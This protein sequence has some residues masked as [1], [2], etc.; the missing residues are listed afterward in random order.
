M[1]RFGRVLGSRRSGRETEAVRIPADLAAELTRHGEPLESIV[2]R[3]LRMHAGEQRDRRGG[4]PGGD[5]EGSM[6]FWLGRGAGRHEAV[7]EAAGDAEMEEELRDRV[8][9]RHE[10][11]QPG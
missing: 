1:A 8:I 4:Q 9:H 10:G 2:L 7:P 6:P 5:A 3:I 11:D